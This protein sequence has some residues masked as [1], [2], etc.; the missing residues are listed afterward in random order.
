MTKGKGRFAQKLGRNTI[1][2]MHETVNSEKWSYRSV[3]DW[4]PFNP[5]GKATKRSRG[6]SARDEIDKKDLKVR[7]IMNLY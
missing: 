5:Q 1:A 6:S 7:S 2:N 3:A 4:P